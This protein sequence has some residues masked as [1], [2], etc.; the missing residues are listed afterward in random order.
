VRL[1][2][3]NALSPLV[4]EGLRLAG[5]DAIHVRDIAAP[6]APDELVLDLA[7][8]EGRVLVSADTDFAEILAVRDTKKPSFV[9]LRP[10][11]ETIGEQI[12]TL[13]NNLPQLQNELEFGV[14]AVIEGFRVRV[15]R[16]PI[17]GPEI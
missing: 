12:S 3:D 9:L 7:A 6:S 17:Q 11:P 1:L 15:R 8:S 14:V 4:A 5:H 13:V 10:V 2:V 16:L